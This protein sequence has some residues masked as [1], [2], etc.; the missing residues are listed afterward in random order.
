MFKAI[1]KLMGRF[2]LYLLSAEGVWMIAI[3]LIILLSAGS[4]GGGGGEYIN[5][6]PTRWNH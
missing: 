2:L 3:I 4:G 6:S 1:E 5:A